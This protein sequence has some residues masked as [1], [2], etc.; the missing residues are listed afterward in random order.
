[1]QPRLLAALAVFFA[2]AACS[3][4]PGASA[5]EGTFFAAPPVVVERRG[6]YTLEWT[7][8]TF[9]F[10]YH[11]ELEV[12]EGRLVVSVRAIASSGSLAGVCR[13]M[14]ITDPDARR[15][16]AKGAYIWEPGPDP[17]GRL[18][19]LVVKHER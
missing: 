8:G 4:G 6:V 18:V 3:R 16:A 17:R 7:Q 10:Y 9:P 15:A 11:P 5:T 12:S 1:M 2:V 13:V 14:P 19:P